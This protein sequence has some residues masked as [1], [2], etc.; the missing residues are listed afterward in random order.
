MELKLLERFALTQLLP[1]KG[2]MTEQLTAKDIR[3]KI[4]VTK[5]DLEAVEFVEEGGFQK[6]NAE[7]DTPKE[8]EFSD[9]EK[10]LLKA[11][12]KKLDD[13]KAITPQILEICVKIE[14][15]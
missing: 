14:G 1:E 7:K 12:V 9:A 10:R 3:A 15:L 4:L 5:L 2:T 11:A 13:D 6:W 8:I